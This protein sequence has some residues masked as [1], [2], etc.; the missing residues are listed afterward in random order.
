MIKNEN[1]GLYTV[2]LHTDYPA[3]FGAIKE[4]ID[5]LDN[6]DLEYDITPGV[7][8]AFRAAASLRAE[9]TLPDVSHTLIITRMS[10][11]TKV[12]E[13]ESI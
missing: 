10:G 6:N 7:S 3:I 4:Q 13:K 5:E 1:K 11:K 12:P 9:Y 2:I 8:A